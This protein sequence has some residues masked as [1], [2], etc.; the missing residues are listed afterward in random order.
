V[1]ANASP[2]LNFPSIV[3]GYETLSAK[4]PPIR[5]S[6]L[7]MLLEGNSGFE[8]VTSKLKTKGVLDGPA[9]VIPRLAVKEITGSLETF[10]RVTWTGGPPGLIGGRGPDTDT[11][12]TG[13]CPDGVEVPLQAPSNKA[14][15]IK[16][17]IPKANK[18][19]F[20]R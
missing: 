20:K 4:L 3:K 12:S 15:R 8:E 14:I 13:C 5:V 7:L 16:T 18:L 2:L 17:T 19:I 9:R 1:Y 10:L 11:T 6:L